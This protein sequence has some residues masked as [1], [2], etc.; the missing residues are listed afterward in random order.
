[1]QMKNTDL[2]LIA[3]ALLAVGVACAGWF[4]GKGFIESRSTD[5]Y[6]TVKGVA[7]KAVEADLVIWPIRYVS[8][9]NV[10]EDVQSK[11]T[12][13][14]AIVTT[15]LED[16]GLPDAAIEVQPADV[17]D[18]FAQAYRSGPV[19]NRFILSQTV[20]VRSSEVG[21]VAEANAELGTLIRQGVVLSTDG[22]KGPFF[23]FTQLNDVKPS[24]IAEATANA[25]EAAEQFARDADSKI[26]G[27]RRAN[28][29]VFQILP[30]DRAP[31]IVEP[32]QR[33]KIVRV[34]S[35]LHYLLGE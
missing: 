23:I 29:G 31:G 15:F 20:M 28:Q 16:M 11:I 33:H 14:A 12:N 8:T 6:V 4:I 26:V 32:R 22:Q 1:M 17:T 9:G 25:R 2:G 24:M 3:S 35:T 13:D 10:L 19:P 5:R 7:E 27:I 18:L 34:V 30:R 21:R